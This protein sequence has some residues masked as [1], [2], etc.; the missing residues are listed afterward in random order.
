MPRQ[1]AQSAERRFAWI[2]QLTKRTKTVPNGIKGTCKS[3]SSHGLRFSYVR[4]FGHY[5]DI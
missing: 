2:V 3:F 4:Q 1:D 5:I